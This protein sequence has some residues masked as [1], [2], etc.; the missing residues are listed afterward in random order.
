MCGDSYALVGEGLRTVGVLHVSQAEAEG[1]CQALCSALTSAGGSASCAAYVYDVR[2]EACVLYSSASQLADL[3]LWDAWWAGATCVKAGAIWA[4]SSLTRLGS[5][6]SIPN[7]WYACRSHGG[8]SSSSSAAAASTPSPDAAAGSGEA[9]LLVEVDLPGEC[10]WT[11]LNGLP[12]A[13]MSACAD[14]C[15]AN[16]T[17]VGAFLLGG[18]CHTRGALAAVSNRSSGSASPRPWLSLPSGPSASAPGREQLH[19]LRLGLAVPPPMFVCAARYDVGGSDL[20]LLRDSEPGA[21]RAACHADAF[22]GTFTLYVNGTCALRAR[23]F[24]NAPERDGTNGPSAAVLQSCLHGERLVYRWAGPQYLMEPYHV[25]WGV[26]NSW[27]TCVPYTDVAGSDIFGQDQATGP[28]CAIVSARAR[29]YTP[30][31]DDVMR[32]RR[33]RALPWAPF[34]AA[35]SPSH[36]QHTLPYLL[37]CPHRPAQSTR[38]AR[39]GSVSFASFLLAP[40]FA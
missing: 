28:E 7:D 10:S 32:L 21:C 1:A 26:D 13:N 18:R 20:A 8:G 39:T 23:P 27:H 17:C 22:C 12:A 6:G 15:A 29:I 16:S 34:G 35:L 40:P 38:P 25:R 24:F 37:R 33:I 9:A 19:C 5:S 11:P 3:Q 14:S 36:A 31:R 4:G 30:P 2:I